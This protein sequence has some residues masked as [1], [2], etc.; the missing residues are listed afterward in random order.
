MDRD[1]LKSSVIIMRDE[2]FKKIRGKN[3]ALN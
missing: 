2:N 3:P 1:L